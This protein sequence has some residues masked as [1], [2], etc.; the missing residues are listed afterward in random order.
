M[1]TDAFRILFIFV[2]F[3]LFFFV[4]KSVCL[5]VWWI[6]QTIQWADYPFKEIIYARIRYEM[7]SKVL[8][9]HGTIKILCLWLTT[10][11]LLIKLLRYLSCF[12]PV[13]LMFIFGKIILNLTPFLNWGILRYKL[14]L[15]LSCLYV[16]LLS[17]A[18]CFLL[19]NLHLFLI[20]TLVV[21]LVTLVGTLVVTLITLVGTLVTLVV[22]LVTLVEILVIPV[23][24]LLF[25]FI[26]GCSS[27]YLLLPFYYL[28]MILSFCSN[29]ALPL[30]Y[31]CSQ[32]DDSQI[33]LLY[34]IQFPIFV[35]FLLFQLKLLNN[36]LCIMMTTNTYLW[37]PNTQDVFSI[38][39]THLIILPVLLL[40][41]TVWHQGIYLAL[42]QW[43][44][45]LVSARHLYWS[46]RPFLRIQNLVTIFVILS[47]SRK[48]LNL[49]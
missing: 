30:Y 33:F 18:W 34:D 28:T 27:S 45:F 4:C 43:T 41:C 12:N 9:P 11:N 17:V 8:I 29:F 13:H 31:L 22:T 40:S 6:D 3:F 49:T 24:F 46:I 19:L 42:F 25:H 39:Y 35:L 15:M 2:V 23:V 47:E 32:L 5:C 20:V 7:N 38:D 48:V 37:H 1:K 16:M 21:T 10:V 44:V 36:I 26:L 14:P